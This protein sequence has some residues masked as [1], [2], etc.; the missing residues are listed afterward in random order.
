M[1]LVIEMVSDLVCPWCWLGLRR[2]KAALTLVPHIQPE[3][4]FR[5]YELDPNI[6]P[7]GVDYRAYMTNKFGGTGEADED[8]QRNRFRAMRDALEQYGRE[9]DIPFDFAGI[10]WRPNTF[11]AHRVVRWAQG[12][13]LGMAAKE[14]LFHAYF[15]EHLDIGDHDVLTQLSGQVGLDPAIVS[16]LLTSDADKDTVRQEENVF[17]QMGVRGVPTYIANR[18]YA[19]QG[20][21]TAEKLAKF[22]T[23]V[24]QADPE[25]VGPS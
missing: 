11:D 15:T 7:G 4:Y 17:L 24:A 19:A 16:G 5:P 22:L 12:Q 1:S 6:P 21:E 3:I 9:E 25:G 2:L 20:A 8:P 18:R 10:K 14:R 23:A 13:G